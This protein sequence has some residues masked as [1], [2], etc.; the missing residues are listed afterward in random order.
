M[1]TYS[2][3][4]CATNYESYYDQ[5][6]NKLTHSANFFN[7]GTANPQWQWSSG[8]N[9]F[10]SKLV[11]AASNDMLSYQTDFDSGSNMYYTQCTDRIDLQNTMQNIA[12]VGKINDMMFPFGQKYGFIEHATHFFVKAVRT[13]NS[14]L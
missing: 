2:Y 6:S 9:G 13:F 8:E 3:D 7:N 1:E 4:Y 12:S 5:Q 11:H 10:I 14:C